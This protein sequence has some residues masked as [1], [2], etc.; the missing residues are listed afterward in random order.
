[1]RRSTMGLWLLKAF[2]IL[3]FLAFGTP[4]GR[5]QSPLRRDPEKV[6]GFANDLLS[7]ADAYRAS[8]EYQAFLFL[9]PRHPRVS[10]A[11]YYLGKSYQA[12]R[13]WDEALEAFRE[14]TNEEFIETP[15]AQE[16]ALEIGETLMMAGRPDSA[17]RSLAE[18]A[19]IPSWR[20]IHGKARCL[21][22]WAWMNDGQYDHALQVL[23]EIPRG[24]VLHMTSKR[25]SDEIMDGLSAL[26]RR[27]PWIAGGLAAT[28]PGSG[29]LYVGQPKEA[30]TSFVLNGAFIVGAIWA[31][32][33]GYPITGGILSFFELS[34]YFG[35][36]SSAAKGA[37]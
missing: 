18:A 29:H 21:A 13:K 15:W 24:D 7:Q 34:W 5:T 3:S 26:P 11:W 25:L 19:R 4:E 22:A 16:A 6:L 31:L 10:E 17:A 20:P 33:E 35:G 37:G 2:L 1:M 27:S 8:S 14:V 28:L 9:F 23:K 36:I 12:Q 30:L 32:K